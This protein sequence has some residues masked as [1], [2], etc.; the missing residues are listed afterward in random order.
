MSRRREPIS[1]ENK[2]IWSLKLTHTLFVMEGESV[3]EKRGIASR[4]WP[5]PLKRRAAMTPTS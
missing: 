4:C 2:R 3:V 1:P 5:M